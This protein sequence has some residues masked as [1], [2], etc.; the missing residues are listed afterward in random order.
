[1]HHACELVLYVGRR[2]SKRKRKR[3][4]RHREEGLQTIN[5]AETRSAF[6]RM[7][8]QKARRAHDEYRSHP[9]ARHA[10]ACSAAR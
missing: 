3:D 6:C 8:T 9:D 10:C 5:E 1:M 7:A 4:E 2:W